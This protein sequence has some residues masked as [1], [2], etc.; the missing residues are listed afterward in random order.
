MSW[1]A[2]LDEPFK[3]LC[4][5]RDVL[6][7]FGVKPELEYTPKTCKGKMGL[8]NVWDK[9]CDGMM[10]LGELKAGIDYW[11]GDKDGVFT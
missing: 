6:L 4:Q 7:E 11:D 9:N 10:T 1:N 2:N 5:K 8:F 3:E